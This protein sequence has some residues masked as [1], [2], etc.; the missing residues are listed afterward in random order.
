MKD[1]LL[2]DL[3]I[4]EIDDLI[5]E[6]QLKEEGYRFYYFIDVNDIGKYTFPFGLVENSSQDGREKRPIELITDEQISYHYL[7]NKNET[8]KQLLLFNEHIEELNDFIAKINRLKSL[9]Y[10]IVDSF[11]KQAL[12]FEQLE[13]GKYISYKD[14]EKNQEIISSQLNVSYFI[15]IVL[16]SLRE[17]K[18]RLLHL[19]D[20]ILNYE[21]EELLP[22]IIDKSLFDKAKPSKLT[23]I[24]FEKLIKDYIKE[25][26]KELNRIYARFSKCIIYD[27]LLKLNEISRKDKDLFILTTSSKSINKRLTKIADDLKLNILINNT[28]FNPVRSISQIYLQLLLQNIQGDDRKAKYEKI[29]SYVSLVKESEE[30]KKEFNEIEEEIT[31]LREKYENTSLLLNE[32]Y[33]SKIWKS[34]LNRR[35]NSYQKICSSIATLADIAKR[36]DILEDLQR[37]SLKQI[38]YIKDFHELLR[39]AIK[40]IR[41]GDSSFHAYSGQDH[42]KNIYDSLPLVYFKEGNTNFKNTIEEIARF[43]IKLPITKKDSQELNASIDKCFSSLYYKIVPNEE[44]KIIMIIIFL[45]LNIPNENE[46]NQI[47]FDYVNE[48]I[49]DYDAKKETD[50]KTWLQAFL[51]IKSW[52]ARRIKDYQKSIDIALQEISKD[53]K[54]PRFYHSAYLSHYNLF[55]DH[56]KDEDLDKAIDYCKKAYNL[57]KEKRKEES[58]FKIATFMATLSL[59]NGLTYLKILRY[60]LKQ[61]QED[62][63]EA[64][65]HLSKLKRIDLN[66]LKI[67]QFAH[68]EATLMK[69]IHRSEEAIQAINRA[70]ELEPDSDYYLKEKRKIEDSI[71]KSED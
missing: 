63:N 57:Y 69:S 13:Q 30:N 24:L 15:S 17:G 50:D 27:R 71:K 67:A 11:I 37:D 31:N 34:K 45:M 42:V 4:R 5:F 60:E 18:E 70:I 6:D 19:K 52:I 1:S 23:D 33:Q 47:A 25:D 68:T 41:T 12:L 55:F 14:W 10:E 29:K 38:E 21:N 35:L 65:E 26:G 7:I 51:Y 61:D 53:E 28:N 32:Y 59:L 16:G 40:K 8:N 56:K 20:T 46:A 48:I 44:E 2:Q 64:K 62:I 36:T 58:E 54:D 22:D 43:V 9:G 3:S 49:S 66:Y 39:I